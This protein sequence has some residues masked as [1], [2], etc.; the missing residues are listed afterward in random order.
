MWL[1]A[2]VWHHIPTRL[3]NA[4]PLKWQRFRLPCLVQ[5]PW[6]ALYVTVLGRI[7]PCSVSQKWNLELGEI[8]IGVDSKVIGNGGENDDSAKEKESENGK[9]YVDGTAASHE[10]KRRRSVNFRSEPWL[11]LAAGS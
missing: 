5:Y 1:N 6:N 4:L 10:G 8:G 9:K 7:P 11:N 2:L 3:R